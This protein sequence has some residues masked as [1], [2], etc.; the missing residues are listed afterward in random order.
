M[1][2]LAAQRARTAESDQSP[3]APDISTL[4]T[5]VGDRAATTRPATFMAQP[6][7]STEAPAPVYRRTWFWVAVSAVVAGGVVAAY[8][9]SQDDPRSS[10]R[11]IDTR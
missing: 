1:D 9:L 3:R 6:G 5:A 4:P 11:P 2:G 10:L 8:A 7:R